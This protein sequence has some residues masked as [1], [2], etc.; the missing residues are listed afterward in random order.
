MKLSDGGRKGELR[1]VRLSKKLGMSGLGDQC[2]WELALPATPSSPASVVLGVQPL[3]F[4]TVLPVSIA[5]CLASP[6]LPFQTFS[7]YTHQNP[8][9]RGC[10]FVYFQSS[11]ACHQPNTT[12][13][14]Q[15]RLGSRLRLAPQGEGMA[16]KLGRHLKR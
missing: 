11:Q 14:G 3:C 1:S 15:G 6:V 5:H 13:P 8:V 7:C 9:C 16:S 10:S 12:K 4:H 2:M